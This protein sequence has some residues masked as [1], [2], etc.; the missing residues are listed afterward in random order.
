MS[1]KVE[2]VD[3]NGNSL[4]ERMFFLERFYLRNKGK[5][6]SL[7][8]ASL[9]G[10]GSYFGYEAYL[11]YKKDIANKAY[12]N[13]THGVDK[14]KSLEIIRETSPKL[15]TLIQFSEAIKSGEVSE[16]EKFANNENQT[17]SDLATYQT[18]SFNR[19]SETLNNY[20]YREGAIYKDLAVVSEAFS[21]IQ[22]GK[23]DEAKQRLSFIEDT[24]ALSKVK[25]ILQH[26]GIASKESDEVVG[27]ISLELPEN[28]EK[29]K[30]EE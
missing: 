30:V 6:I 15:L 14:E 27:E 19:D 17:I 26:Y 28:I 18:A 2:I 13:Y 8:V 24:S 7:S 9:L 10:I 29:V 1:E 21:L 23:I 3:K 16:I 12:Y 25:N 5:I 20:S 11:N 4:E 22:S